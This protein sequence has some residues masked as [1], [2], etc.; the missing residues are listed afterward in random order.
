MPF[1][2]RYR[3]FGDK[4]ATNRPI[5]PLYIV[6]SRHELSSPIRGGCILLRSARLRVLARFVIRRR[7]Y[8]LAVG[9]PPRDETSSELQTTRRLRNAGRGERDGPTQGRAVVP[10]PRQPPSSSQGRF[11]HRAPGSELRAV[12]GD[13]GEDLVSLL[14]AIPFLRPQDPSPGATPLF[15]HRKI[16]LPSFRPPSHFRFAWSI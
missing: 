12:S 15:A 9:R 14:R 10:L 8:D 3:R 6:Y 16:L 5:C 7:W 1:S 2:S 4:R 13:P 11:S